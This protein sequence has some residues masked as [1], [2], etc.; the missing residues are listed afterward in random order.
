MPII[1]LPSLFPDADNAF[2]LGD[3]N[4]SFFF[5]PSKSLRDN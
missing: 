5:S 1:S 2:G 3:I 4:P